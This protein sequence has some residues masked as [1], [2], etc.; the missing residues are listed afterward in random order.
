MKITS[1]SFTTFKRSYL[2][3]PSEDKGFHYLAK[4]K[5]VTIN[6]LLLGLL[7]DLY[8]NT[9]RVILN[10]TS[11]DFMRLHETSRDFDGLRGTSRDFMGLGET[12][13]GFGR[14]QKNFDGLR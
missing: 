5:P 4:N 10:G 13:W 7:Q 3:A 2:Y 8:R 12:S 9:K 6:I 11:R 1:W 14:L